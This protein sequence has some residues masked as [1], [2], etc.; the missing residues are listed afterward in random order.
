MSLPAY[1]ARDC[2]RCELCVKANA[3]IHPRG[4]DR[5]QLLIVGEA[6]GPQENEAKTP[7]IGPSGQLLDEMLKEAGIPEADVRWTNA[8]RCWPSDDH[9]KTIRPSD[10]ALTKC[11]PYLDEEIE[12]V[13]PKAI[14]CLGAVATKSLLGLRAAMGTLHGQITQYKGIPVIPTYH[15]A[16]VLRGNLEARAA[17]VGDLQI[18]RMQYHRT[19]NAPVDYRLIT[20]KRDLHELVDRLIADCRDKRLQHGAIAVDLETTGLH[21]F[22]PKAAI[23]SIQIAWGTGQAALI[24]LFHN[25]LMGR[26]FTT[27][28]GAASFQRNIK[29]LLESGIPVVGHNYSFDHKWLYSKLGIETRNVRFDT[30]YAQHCLT[31]G[32]RP[33]SLGYLSSAYLGF[34][35]YK[36]QMKGALKGQTMA[37]TAM[38]ELVEYG[39]RDADATLRLYPMLKEK[40]KQADRLSTFKRFYMGTWRTLAAMESDGILL[41]PKRLAELEPLYLDVM[42]ATAKTIRALPQHT[43]WMAEVAPK[44]KKGLAPTLNPVSARHV[45]SFLYRTLGCPTVNEAGEESVSSKEKRLIELGRWAYR[46]DRG[47]VYTTVINVIRHR[48]AKT[49]LTRYVKK[50]LEEIQNRGEESRWATRCF[51]PPQLPWLIHSNFG[52]TKTVTGRLSSNDPNLQNFPRGSV[53]RSAG[54]SRFT[55]GS[56]LKADFS[57]N[58]L[59]VLAAL[60]GDENL[61]A[62]LSGT[63]PR[64]KEFGGDVHLYTASVILRKPREQVTKEERHRAKAVSFGII[65]GRGARAIALEYGISKEDAQALVDAYFRTFP[66]VKAFIDACHTQ[67]HRHGYLIGPTGRYYPLPDGKL[68]SIR[69]HDRSQDEKRRLGEAER[70]AVNY[71]IQGPASDIGLAA[72]VDFRRELVEMSLKSRPFAFI[73]DSIECDLNTPELFQVYDLLQTSML[74]DR[75][76]GFEWL[77]ASLKVEFEWG[78]D[79]QATMACELAGNE[80]TLSGNRDHYVRLRPCIEHWF[81]IEREDIVSEGIRDDRTKE[82]PALKTEDIEDVQPYEKI[83]VTLKLK[84]KTL[85]ARSTGRVEVDASPAVCNQ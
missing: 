11:R 71:P 3:L 50:L 31:G 37:S 74:G 47:D 1:L 59:R 82:G 68:H 65:Y 33:A 9:G 53:I 48:H 78:R 12:H 72:L 51:E 38:D 73:H 17:I 70:A 80:V 24:P 35:P 28:D 30:M 52:L 61:L 16:F 83:S 39:C 57:Q 22:D 44:N 67:V 2:E 64:F 13:R 69:Y 20:K 40:L 63:D 41:D 45:S 6:P 15:P 76:K 79:W 32:S 36:R 81:D 42:A 8:V 14:V 25:D 27:V 85:G 5:P 66:K 10:N 26:A 54:I 21:A 62:V 77:T 34:P 18:A 56:F 43:S 29:F 84:E 46:H 23:V 58:E 55:F 7:F 60:A 4:S 19:V 75:G 49:R